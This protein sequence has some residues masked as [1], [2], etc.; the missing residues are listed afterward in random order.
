MLAVQEAELS[1][2]PSIPCL[3]EEGGIGILGLIR[4]RW[5]AALEYS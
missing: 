5:L 4:K 3:I 2:S 1:S